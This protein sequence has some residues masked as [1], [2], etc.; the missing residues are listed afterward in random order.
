MRKVSGTNL[1]KQ[2]VSESGRQHWA[3]PTLFSPEELLPTFSH[4]SVSPRLFF[5][6]NPGSVTIL[7]FEIHFLPGRYFVVQVSSCHTSE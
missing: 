2:H 5:D 1:L 4:D 3:K 7:L 6:T